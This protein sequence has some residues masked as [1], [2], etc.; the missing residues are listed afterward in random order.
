MYICTTTCKYIHTIVATCKYFCTYFLHTYWNVFTYIRI[1]TYIGK[2]FCSYIKRVRIHSVY[3]HGYVQIQS[4]LR[5]DTKIDMCSYNQV[6][7]SCRFCAQITNQD[8]WIQHIHSVKLYWPQPWECPLLP[9]A[10]LLSTPAWR[11]R[12][13]ARGLPTKF[14]NVNVP[15]SNQSVACT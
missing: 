9:S 15:P 2:Y 7:V 1:C 4:E 13:R 11:A 8:R 10:P 12:R 6:Y 5:A 3:K 14:C